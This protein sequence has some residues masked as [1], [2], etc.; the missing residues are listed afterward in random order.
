MKQCLYR[1][2]M[3]NILWWIYKGCTNIYFPLY[4]TKIGNKF[5][6][7]G[8]KVEKIRRIKFGLTEEENNRIE[9]ETNK[10]LDEI[11]NNKGGKK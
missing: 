1:D 5:G 4:R 10:I 7:F 2:I 6:D 11:M 9:F 3:R 8:N